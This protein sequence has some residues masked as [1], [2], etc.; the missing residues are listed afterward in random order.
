MRKVLILS[1]YFPPCNGAP[2]WRP[3]SWARNFHLHGWYPVIV[4]R[5][6]K[7][8]ESSWEDFLKDD[9]RPLNHVK[10]SE[11]ELYSLPTRRFRLNDV[12]K[13]KGL[14]PRMLANFYYFLLGVFGRFNS[15]IDA[16]LTFREFTLNLLKTQDF[17]AVIVT[18]PPSVILRLIPDI[19]RL[20]KAVVVADIRDLWNNMLLR[21]N[22]KPSFKQRIWDFLYSSYY[23]KWLKNVHAIT[24]IVEQFIPVLKKLSEA[25]VHVIY[26]GFESYQFENVIRD[27]KDKFCFSV[28]GNIYPEQDI[29]VLLNGLTKFLKGKSPALI[30]IRFIGVDAL[31]EIGAKVRDNIPADFLTITGRVNKET[32]VY[33]T[34]N[35]TVLSYPGWKGVKGIISTKAF[36][37][38]ASGNPILIAPGDGD[39][40]DNL[41]AEAGTG[42]SVNDVASFVEQLECW[43]EEWLKSGTIKLGSNPEK[44][45]FYSR[46]NQALRMASLLDAL[47]ATVK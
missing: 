35:A 18:S 11:F 16:D 5:H 46:E 36:D 31:G 1:Y 17:D 13:G 15:E 23:R 41:V 2:S 27:R 6:W 39:V 24:V 34:A 28:I 44:I 38:I 33:E 25:P 20:T 19:Q 47:Q 21:D 43:F 8:D 10:N 7:G 37:Y 9:L 42:V 22:Y 3:F 14:L 32:A 29:S 45:N 26:N 40:L 4:S 30:N 12:L